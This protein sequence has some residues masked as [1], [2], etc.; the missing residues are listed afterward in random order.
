M[1]GISTWGDSVVKQYRDAYRVA[2]AII[3][4][5]NAIKAI[6][7]IFA[8]IIGLAVL[9][10]VIESSKF[11]GPGEM[12]VVAGVIAAAFVGLLFW[13][14]GVLITSQGQV[15]LASL[16]GAVNGSPF[17]T[18]NQRADVMSLPKVGASGPTE[19]VPIF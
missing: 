16:D 15:L 1:E 19:E 13:L 8:A 6:G 7:A 14:F 17:L 9:V 4:I 3:A 18:D 12:V 5:G 10:I 2:T 11:G